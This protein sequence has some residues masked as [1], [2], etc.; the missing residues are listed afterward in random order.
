MSCYVYCMMFKGVKTALVL[1]AQSFK[2][3]TQ[4]GAAKKNKATDQNI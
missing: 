2:R 3:F 4:S 1:D